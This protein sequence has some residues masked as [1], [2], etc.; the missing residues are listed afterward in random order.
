M[1]AEVHFVNGKMMIRKSMIEDFSICPYKFKRV[2]IEHEVKKPNQVMAVG[3]RFHD[4]ANQ[5]FDFAGAVD[6]DEWEYFIH[7]D[8][9][10]MEV[11]MLLWFINRERNRYYN[12]EA[13]D[14]LD[15]WMPL[16]REQKLESH[17]YYLESTVDRIDWWDKK[18][19][20]LC[21]VEYKT[22]GKVNDTSLVRQLAFYTLAWEDMIGYGKVVNLQLVNPKLGVVRD[23]KLH[24]RMLD[25]VMQDVMKLRKALREQNF[26]RKCNEIIYPYCMMCS[27]DEC[28]IWK[29]SDTIS[30]FVDL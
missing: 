24:D 2:W 19:G 1:G 18:N 4:F 25:R 23:Y 17:T 26:P 11:D 13:Q 3:T 5:F 7:P 20:E 28:G 15:E 6:P 16:F 10:P 30:S 8:F 29:E 22:G 9:K 21:I 12:L 14:R 27:P